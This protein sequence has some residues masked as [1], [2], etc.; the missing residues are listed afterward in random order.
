MTTQAK[1]P[2]TDWGPEKNE[3]SSNQLD[4]HL[5]K[6]PTDLDDATHILREK[7]MRV[8]ARL[9]IKLPQDAEKRLS[10]GFL[11]PLWA[12]AGTYWGE[13][14]IA[15]R[16]L[17]RICGRVLLVGAGV[18]DDID[19]DTWVLDRSMSFVDRLAD[20]LVDCLKKTPNVLGNQAVFE[21]V[22]AE[23]SKPPPAA[24]PLVEI[25]DKDLA[26]RKTAGNPPEETVEARKLRLHTL[27]FDTIKALGYK[28]PRPLTPEGYLPAIT[29]K[30]LYRLFPLG[31]LHDPELAARRA[32]VLERIAAEPEIYD[33]KVVEEQVFSLTREEAQTVADG[34]VQLENDPGMCAFLSAR[35][36]SASDAHPN[37]AL[38]APKES[39]KPE[40]SC[41]GPC[42][43]NKPC[44]LCN[45]DRAE[46]LAIAWQY[47]QAAGL[48]QYVGNADKLDP[49]S[50]EFIRGVI[51]KG[52]RHD[53][54]GKRLLYRLIS[55][56][57]DENVDE[58]QLKESVANIDAQIQSFVDTKRRPE[59][60]KAK[61]IAGT[62]DRLVYNAPA[63]RRWV[64]ELMSRCPG[65]LRHYAGDTGLGALSDHFVRE[66]RRK[67]VTEDSETLKKR[68]EA[69]LHMA[70]TKTDG[71]NAFHEVWKKPLNRKADSDI[72]QMPVD[73]LN[74]F[75][76]V[77]E[78]YNK[79]QTD[80]IGFF[81]KSPAFQFG[82]SAG[83]PD[84]PAAHVAG[85]ISKALKIDDELAQWMVKCLTWHFKTGLY[86]DNSGVETDGDRGLRAGLRALLCH[87][88]L[89]YNSN[90]ADLFV[91]RLSRRALGE[92]TKAFLTYFIF[93]R[94][95]RSHTYAGHLKFGVDQCR[96][97]QPR[98]FTAT[99][100]ADFASE[101]NGVL[102]GI[103]ATRVNLDSEPPPGVVVEKCNAGAKKDSA[104][105]HP[106]LVVTPEKDLAAPALSAEEQDE[107]FRSM[108]DMAN[109]QTPE[110]AFGNP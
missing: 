110:Q 35:G 75:I 53:I 63:T 24:K 17:I 88:G 106:E 92:I 46:L 55:G 1:Q 98:K 37:D 105:N 8:L 81:V 14:H 102:S 109:T 10:S 70:F 87:Y 69:R 89:D 25:S 38:G 13:T 93:S 95:A 9:D 16:A 30:L 101:R 6:P 64:R 85:L 23:C 28:L 79:A 4:G 31:E 15:K 60:E 71:G 83:D 12:R 104:W 99:E 58:L 50:T 40:C 77:I 61:Q 103:G 80:Y 94:P 18:S 57:S 54:T 74:K 27:L 5:Q 36:N 82:A 96:I 67:A 100:I 78:D 7:T 39:E 107:V 21:Q 90:V 52:E 2:D 59:T 66:I 44:G 65:V 48:S 29:D 42:T 33:D 22:A 68:V 84:V 51:E 32:F 76:A 49:L 72:L 62:E 19:L 26:A 91:L 11:F 3:C 47:L 41:S 97:G 45:L 56:G 34:C 73:E 86:R 108:S 43:A 20:K